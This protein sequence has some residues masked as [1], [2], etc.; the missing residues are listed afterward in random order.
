MKTRLTWK[1]QNEQN[2]NVSCALL[3]LKPM[4]KKMTDWEQKFM[5]SIRFQNEQLGDILTEG[6][7]K[8]LMEIKVKYGV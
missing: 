2:K 8:K 5:R 6:Q 1:E 3:K 4:Y 7:F